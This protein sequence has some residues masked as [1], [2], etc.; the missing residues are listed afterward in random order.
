[1]VMDEPPVRDGGPFSFSKH[2]PCGPERESFVPENLPVGASRRDGTSLAPVL[3]GIRSRSTAASPHHVATRLSHPL[4]PSPDGSEPPRGARDLVGWRH[5]GRGEVAPEQAGS[6]G[7]DLRGSGN[8]VPVGGG[9][10]G[11]F[12]ALGAF[13]AGSARAQSGGAEMPVGSS[14]LDDAGPRARMITGWCNSCYLASTR[15]QGASPLIAR[16]VTR[17]ARIRGPSPKEGERRWKK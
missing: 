5:V 14:P 2:K 8:K 7:T 3:F 15:P 16:A 11:G 13:G 1:M 4:N 12:A 9:R 17:S 10:T 6:S